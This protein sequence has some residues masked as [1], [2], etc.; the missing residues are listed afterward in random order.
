MLEWDVLNLLDAVYLLGI[1]C[2]SR[3]YFSYDAEIRLLVD[4]EHA[5]DEIDL[6]SH[7]LLTFVRLLLESLL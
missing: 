5:N 3:L 4:D 6:L 2:G 1:E 7:H